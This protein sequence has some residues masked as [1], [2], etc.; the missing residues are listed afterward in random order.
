MHILDHRLL[1]LS[2]WTQTFGRCCY[3]VQPPGQELRCHCVPPPRQEERGQE[4]G[5]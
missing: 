2:H 3:C 4:K 5:Q 1:P